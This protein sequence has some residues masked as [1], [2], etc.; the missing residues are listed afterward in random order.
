MLRQLSTLAAGFSLLLASFAAS[1]SPIIINSSNIV[2]IAN[3]AIGSGRTVEDTSTAFGSRS[4]LAIDGAANSSTNINWVDTGS[5]ALFDFDMNHTRTG[6]LN[7]FSQSYEA[8]LRFTA[9]AN[10]TYSLTGDYSADDITSAGRIYSY[11]G[12]RNISTNSFLFRDLNDSRNTLDESFMIGIGG[13]GDY[14]NLFVGSQTGL[15]VAGD[16]YE[17]F[18]QNVIQAISI[19]DGGASATGC[20]TLSIGGATG[21]GSCGSSV[22]EPMPLTMLG[23]GLAALGLRRKFLTKAV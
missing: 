11:V 12:L 20:V 14:H 13:E 22:P 21:A 8:V 5:G 7:S 4:L 1:A 16:Q 17:L 10:T 2:S 23:A 15:L 9:G 19:A 3:D 18:F 6:A